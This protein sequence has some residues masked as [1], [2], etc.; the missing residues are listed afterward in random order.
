MTFQDEDF[1][2]EYE[3]F[4]NYIINNFYVLSHNVFI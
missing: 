2:N 3:D 4:V 1:L